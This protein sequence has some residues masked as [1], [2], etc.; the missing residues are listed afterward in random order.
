MT[1]ALREARAT[2][3][4]TQARVAELAEIS[5]MS[6]MRYE[7]GQRSPDANT[8]IRIAKALDCNVE[9]LFSKDK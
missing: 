3:G 1:L 7:N 4:M 5:T 2:A 9:D 8:L 6:Y